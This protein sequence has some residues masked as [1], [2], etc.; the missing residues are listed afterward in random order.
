MKHYLLILYF[1]AIS[2][3]VFAQKPCYFCDTLPPY[4]HSIMVQANRSFDNIRDFASYLVDRAEY[5]GPKMFYA[6]F[7]YGYRVHKNII[8][9][10]E[11]MFLSQK[12]HLV[13]EILYGTSFN[14][15]G[16][17]RFLVNKWLVFKPYADVGMSYNYAHS[18]Y[19]WPEFYQPT[20]EETQRFRPYNF[21]KYDAYIAPGMSFM[22]WRNHI[23][24]DL[25]VKFSPFRSNVNSKMYVFTWK[26]GYNF[27]SK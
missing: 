5:D 18:K 13:K 11:L 19:S 26:L 10:P 22:I 21:H 1:L 16:Y 24:I 3:M 15:G 2:C 7:R 17:A 27:N 14:I 8:V 20:D 6:D 25:G 9:G 4:K 12:R 23:N